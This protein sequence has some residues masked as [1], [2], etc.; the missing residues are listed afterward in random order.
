MSTE[1]YTFTELC[2]RAGVS[3]RTVRYYVAQGLLPSPGTGRAARWR[4]DHL[5]RLDLI[6][7]LKEKHLPLA[8]IRL[9]LEAM[10]ALEVQDLVAV[11]R[12]EPRPSTAS[13]YVQK[14]LAGMRPAAGPPP[15][16]ARAL[17]TAAPAPR[18][19]PSRS[20]WE[21]IPLSPD[22]ELHIRRPLTREQDRRVQRLLTLAHDLF[23][24]EEP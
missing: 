16:Q 22:V 10:T 2:V 4:G 12:Q 21:H 23:E 19:P 14:V 20:T 15:G 17:S 5:R 7:Q 13:E 9:K 24:K 6:L 11:Q 1:T 8:E 3:E 18:H